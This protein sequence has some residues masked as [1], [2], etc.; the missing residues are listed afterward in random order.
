MRVRLATYM[1]LGILALLVVKYLLLG[2]N[3]WDNVF[4]PGRT[5]P[6]SSVFL[7][8]LLGGIRLRIKSRI[9]GARNNGDGD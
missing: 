3:V 5:E 6:N 8:P 4:H 7:N 1:V 2:L 9:R